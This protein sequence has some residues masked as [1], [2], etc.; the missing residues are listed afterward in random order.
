[1]FIDYKHNTT[2]GYGISSLTWTKAQSDIFLSSFYV[3]LQ[4]TKV[5]YNIV[6][7]LKFY[8]KVLEKAE[9]TLNARVAM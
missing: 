3:N 1:M 2:R 5:Y 9:E 6:H 8:T 7:D 4:E